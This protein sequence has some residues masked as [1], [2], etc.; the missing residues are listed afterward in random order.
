LGLL[1]DGD[2]LLERDE[3]YRLAFENIKAGTEHLGFRIEYFDYHLKWKR[4]TEIAL[5]SMPDIPRIYRERRGV[6]PSLTFAPDR[7]FHIN[8]GVN[9]TSLQIQYPQTHTQNANALSVTATYRDVWQD[10]AANRHR[11]SL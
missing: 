6:E 8:A 11:V 2:A 1:D 5:S 9:V 10:R 7:R 4:E 3:G